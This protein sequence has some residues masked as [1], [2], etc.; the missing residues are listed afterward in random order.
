M[1]EGYIDATGQ[2]AELLRENA[3]V[4]ASCIFYPAGNDFRIEAKSLIFP[5]DQED[6]FR[7]EEP[8][9][10]IRQV[11]SIADSYLRWQFNYPQEKIDYRNY[12]TFLHLAGGK[13]GIIFKK[14]TPFP[15]WCM[16]LPPLSY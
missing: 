10:W 3:L 7:H 2:M 12:R 4:Y 8:D 5:G 14:P 1:D 16:D 6:S 11:R 15:G 13:K 9:W